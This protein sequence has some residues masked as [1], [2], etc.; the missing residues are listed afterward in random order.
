[1]SRQYRSS[2]LS[3]SYQWRFTVVPPIMCIALTTLAVGQWMGKQTGCYADSLAANPNRPTVTNPAH[4]TQ[5]GVVEV[6]YGWDRFW[7]EQGGHQTSMGGLLK[8]G[9]LCDIEFRWNTTSFL[10]QTD[11]SGT[12]RTFG[13][14]WL[15]TEIRFHRQTRRL[16]TMA[17]SYALKIPSASTE[18]G[19]GTGRVDHSFGFGASENV[20][21]F[22][23]DFNFT[24]FLNGRPKTSGFDQNQLLALAFSRPIKGGLQFVGEFYGETQLN[25]TTPG[26]ASSIWAL[27]YTVVPRLVV[28][29]GFETGLSAGGPHRHAFFGATYSI[30]NVYR[31]LRKRSGIAPD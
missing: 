29:G 19:L 6:E 23:F 16:P 18:D 4:V 1:V 25:Q 15:G 2:Y 12:T 11:A 5:Y 3:A 13:D 22:N 30:G 26:F 8:F 20:A 21:H 28:D 7:P 27:T 9:M 31:G 10:S 14:N 24:Q 17:F